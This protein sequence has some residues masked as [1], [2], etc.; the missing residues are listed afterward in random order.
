MLM[1]DNKKHKKH[2]VKLMEAKT[3]SNCLSKQSWKTLKSEKSS[4]DYSNGLDK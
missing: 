3:S 2:I 4:H 1:N